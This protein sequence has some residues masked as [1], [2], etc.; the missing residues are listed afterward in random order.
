[1]Y[2][3]M[4]SWPALVAGLVLSVSAQQSGWQDGQV[5]TTLCRWYDF[6][7]ATLKDKV[8]L[9]GG[10][11]F[12]VP[13]MADGSLRP[14]VDDGNP[15][16]LINVL[17]FSTPFNAST[18]ASMLF[19]TISKAPN[20]G[21]ANNFAPNYYGGALLANNDEFFL[22][23]G[24]TVAETNFSP[25]DGD[26]VLG[27][28]ASQYGDNGRSF[29]AG[30]LNANLPDGVTGYV[31][32]GGAVNVPSENKAWYFGGLRTASW[33][34]IYNNYDNATYTPTN[35]SNSFVKLDMTTQQQETWSNVTLPRG[36]PSRAGSSVV[37]VPIGEQGILVVLG[38]VTYPSFVGDSGNSA[39]PAQNKQDSPG[40]MSN[41]DIYDIAGDTWYQQP[42]IGSPSQ[43]ALGCAVVATAQD[44]SSFNIYYYGGYDA[45]SE[46]SDM[47][48]DVWVLSL[49]SFMW[50]KVTS[51]AN[52]EHG[53]AGHQCV[54]PY[55]DQMITIGGRASGGP[56][57][58]LEGDPPEFFQVYNLTAGH[59]MDSYDP[60]SWNEYGVPEMIHIMIGGDYS[61]SATMTTP[62]PSGWATPELAS[63]FATPYPTT[64][65]T[66]YYP[67]S[68]VG[69]G[70]GTRGALNNGGGGGG[71]PSWVGPVLG[72]VLG[73]IF[74]T[75]IVVAVVLYRRRKFLGKKNGSEHSTDENG[76]IRTWREGVHPNDGKAPTVSTDDTHTQLDEMESR[77]ITPMRS[78]PGQPE[79]RQY[80]PSEMPDTP[81]VELPDT[82]TMSELPG[83]AIDSKN[84]PFTSAPQTPRS[85]LTP[86]S[87]TF[88]L[89]GSTFSQDHA[90]SLYP[91]SSSGP[92]ASS[93][94]QINER[95][96][97]PSLGN[98]ERGFG[99]IASITNPASNET[100]HSP[101][102]QQTSGPPPVSPPLPVSPPSVV[103]D[104][105]GEATDYISVHRDNSSSSA[106]G[107]PFRRSVFR[108]NDLGGEERDQQ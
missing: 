70:N 26:Q 16:G 51:S 48:D 95:P 13:G 60:E 90:S 36:I 35:I 72:V 27:Y 21:A 64:K 38:G 34:Q 101:P 75:A 80:T 57:Q 3:Y 102:Q 41:I 49:P 14:P 91:S 32:Y 59:W 40:F 96:D 69:A 99:N 18:N 83:Q 88:L 20:G 28:R 30:F 8:Y 31:T 85:I 12:W 58:C 43:Y 11:L 45:I 100:R 62:T 42:T 46:D 66:T 24:A 23:G 10:H 76:D 53:R 94:T 6:R 39:N 103:V 98:G 78:P 55:P 7:V 68:T 54:M 5:N 25:P 92:V 33:G 89:G 104:G 67:Y 22:Y 61:G 17:N 65:L 108:E 56:D 74:I 84:S 47:N 19:T 50:M 86:T 77:G 4:I 87:Q 97:S 82:S 29:Q 37:W 93:L 71:T 2:R 15:L 52:L 79:M 73:L 63:V 105:P 107:N 106:A 81:L 1:M 44:H 9:D